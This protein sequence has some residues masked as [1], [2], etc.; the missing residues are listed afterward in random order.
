MGYA[1]ILGDRN[2]QTKKKDHCPEDIMSTDDA[3]TLVKW[4]SL[5]IMEVCKNDGT[6]YP[7]VMIHFLLC[8]LQRITQHQNSHPFGIFAKKTFAFT[9]YIHYWIT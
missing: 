7:L 3:K 5:L 9:H 1:G 8:G 6:E 2:T 4:L